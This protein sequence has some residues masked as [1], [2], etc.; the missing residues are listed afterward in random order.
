MNK[1]ISMDIFNFGREEAEQYGD[2]V[3]EKLAGKT[4][5]KRK[6]DIDKPGGLR[7]EAERLGIEGFDMYTLLRTLEGLCYMRSAAE[8]EDGLY[9]VRERA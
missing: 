5:S 7:Y 6:C 4:I 9:K 2:I 3:R 1:E 8:I